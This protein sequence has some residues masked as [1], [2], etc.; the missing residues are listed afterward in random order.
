LFH[1]SNNLYAKKQEA[2]QQTVQL[3]DDTEDRYV[4]HKAIKTQPKHNHDMSEGLLKGVTAES[5][6]QR[7][8]PPTSGWYVGAAVPANL[9]AS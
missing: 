1:S 5:D 7:F 9:P 4:I 6:A 2:I 3:R 8:V